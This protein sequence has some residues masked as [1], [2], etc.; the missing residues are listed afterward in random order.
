MMRLIRDWELPGGGLAISH[1][2]RVLLVRGY[3]VADRASGA[4]VTPRTRFW[5]ADRSVG[6]WPTSSKVCSQFENPV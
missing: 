3:G 4:P 6:G 5:K 2:G 1:N